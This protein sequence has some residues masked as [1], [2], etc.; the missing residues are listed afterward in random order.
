MSLSKGETQY[1]LIDH[2][3]LERTVFAD[4]VVRFMYFI[5]KSPLSVLHRV[6]TL[7]TLFSSSVPFKVLVGLRETDTVKGLVPRLHL[8]CVSSLSPR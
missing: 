4:N 6:L 7:R 2:G 3:L 8:E 5:G 1:C